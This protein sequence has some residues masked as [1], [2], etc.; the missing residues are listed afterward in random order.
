MTAACAG[1]RPSLEESGASREVADSSD[2]P[3]STTDP[4]IS[5][6]LGVGPEWSPEPAAAGPTALGNRVVAALVYEG[7]TSL[8]RR[9]DVQ[10]A[11]AERWF[12]SDDRLQWTFVLPADLTD[13][14]GLVID[15]RAVKA[16]LE[17]LA[18]LGAADQ[19]V[20]LLSPIQGWDAL[21]AGESGGASGITA[22]DATTLVITLD[23][24]FEP[25][26]FVLA[27]PAF[28]VTGTAADGTRRTTGAYAFGAAD[29]ELVAVDPDAAVASIE[30]IVSDE[31]GAELLADGRVDWAVLGADDDPDLVPGDVLR[32]PLELEIGLL[33]RFD[34]PDTRHAVFGALNAPELAL[35][36]EHVG[37][38]A[39]P[40][41]EPRPDDLPEL[42]TIHLP[43]G[44]L[45][46]L[47][48]ELERQL[49]AVDVAPTFVEL[50]PGAFASAVRS[51]EAGLFPMVFAGAGAIR[52]VGVPAASPGGADDPFGVEDGF[53]A[54]LI[55]EIWAER[56]PARR[57]VLADAAESILTDTHLWL[58][59]AQ[60]EVLVGLSDA[61]TPLRILTDGTLDLSGF[62]S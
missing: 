13:N 16:S 44:P 11:L 39:A 61:M 49:T 4:G 34:D 56:D 32:Q 52:T 57:A 2:A 36:L 17:R 46:G 31:P 22:A 23:A 58:P 6:R 5:L 62:G 26:P 10:S 24:P 20:R 3:T 28:G 55:A 35:E 54:S 47:R 15:A 18:S 37:I 14:H 1:D 53:R 50:D 48:D 43:T 45:A 33:A 21:V 38:G 8:D 40:I 25:L 51:G 9:G 42:L 19:T 59:L 27:E 30:L 60:S 12:V 7:L 41:I 29:R